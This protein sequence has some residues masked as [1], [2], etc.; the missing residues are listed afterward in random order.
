LPGAVL[1]AKVLAV[2]VHAVAAAPPPAEAEPAEPAAPAIP[3]E[4]VS[5]ESG[6]DPTVVNTSNP[7]RPA[8]AYQIITSTWAA[9]GGTE[10]APTA[11][12]AT[13]EQQGV[14][15][16]RIAYEGYGSTP[17]QGPGAWECW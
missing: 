13:L 1:T 9:Y 3:A 6:G 10:F 16:G 5:C 7:E 8:G 2:A 15:A 11:D 17:P 4:V 14:I 12:L